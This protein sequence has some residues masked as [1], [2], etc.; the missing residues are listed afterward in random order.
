MYNAPLIEAAGRGFES[1]VIL[2]PDD[3]VAEFATA[4]IMIVKDGIVRTPVAD[5]TFLAGITR[6]RVMSLLRGD[7]VL[8][9]EVRMSTPAATQIPPLTATSKSPT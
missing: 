2:G 6:S 7:G 5:G 9:E 3:Q 8:V 4:N 1:A